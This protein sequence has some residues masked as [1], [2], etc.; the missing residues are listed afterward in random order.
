MPPHIRFFQPHAGSNFINI[1]SSDCHWSLERHRSG[2]NKETDSKWL[3]RRCKLP[4]PYICDDPFGDKRFEA[5]GR[6]YQPSGN[7]QR[8]VA[9]AAQHFGSIDLLVN[10]AGTR[11]AKKCETTIDDLR[12]QPRE[13]HPGVRFLCG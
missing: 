11:H 6:R 9:T 1:Q 10:N 7:A 13:G 2:G 3:S 5:G 4:A 12:P 8:V